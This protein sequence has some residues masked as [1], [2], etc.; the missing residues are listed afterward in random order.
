MSLTPLPVFWMFSALAPVSTRIFGFLKTRSSSFETVF[1]FDGHDAREHLETGDIGAE[2]VEHGGEFDAHG[3][4]ADDDQAT[5]GRREVE[6]FDVGEDESASGCEAGEHARFRAGGDDD[7]F[8]FEASARRYRCVTSTLPPPLRVA[9]PLMRSTLF[10]FEQ[11]LDA[12]GVLGDDAVLAL[13]DFGVIEARVFD[14]GCPVGSALAKCS[15]TSAVWS[16]ALVGMQPTSRQVPPSLAGLFDE[17]GFESVLAGAHGCRVAAGAAPNDNQIVGHFYYSSGR[18]GKCPRTI[19]GAH[20]SG[21]QTGAA[22]F[23]VNPVTDGAGSGFRKDG[24]THASLVCHR[25]RLAFS[26]ESPVCDVRGGFAPKRLSTT[27]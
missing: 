5:S 4:R 1:V 24:G 9:K 17:G 8:R 20:I 16:R 21:G 19:M 18:M 23:P 12:L 26:R 14:S 3:A 10:S 2:A 25:G 11:Q 15:Q 22:N 7:V 13:D 6:N 27:C